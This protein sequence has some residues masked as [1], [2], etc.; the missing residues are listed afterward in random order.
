MTAE[1]VAGRRRTDYLLTELSE[2]TGVPPRTI[3]YYQAKGLLPRP[4]RRGNRAVYSE[5]HLNLLKSV[6]E[7]QAEGLRLQTIR[8]MLN[9]DVDSGASMVDLLGPNLSGSAWLRT[10]ARTLDEGEL[11]DLLGDAYPESV[12]DLVKF[13]YLERRTGPGGRGAWFAPS[14]PQLRGA[15]ELQKVGTDIELSAWSADLMRRRFRAL[16]EEF[17]VKWISE[18]GDH[19]AGSGTQEEFEQNLEII[20]AVTW[21]SAAHV[22]AE[23]IEAVI[24]RVD[25]IREGMEPDGAPPGVCSKSV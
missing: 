6:G 18:A 19:F 9:G 24:H 4:S 5:E 2:L 23:E 22:M 11:A 10:S 13:G 17:A 3:R 14:V 20:R 15:L 12:S 21:Q 1:P 25:E 7:L 8:S 16:C